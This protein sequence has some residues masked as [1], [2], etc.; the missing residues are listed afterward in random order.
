VIVKR[1]LFLTLLATALGACGTPTPAGTAG[2]ASTAVA[3]TA[4]E[5]A[6]PGAGTAVTASTSIAKTGTAGATTTALEHVTV[7][8]GY[9]P[10]VQF[11]P[12]YVAARKGYYAAEGLDV[13]FNYGGNVNDLLLQSASGKLPFLI[14][15]GDEVLVARTQQIPVE[16][17]FL[18][19]QR[20]PVAVFSKQAAGITRPQDLKGKTIGIPGRYGA[21]YIG[22]RGLL[23]AAG[24]QES[25]VNLSEIGF[26]QF[27]AVSSGKVPVAVGYANNDA[28]RLQDAGMPVNV[29]KVGD[30]IQ[31]VNNG[32][33]VSEAY[34]AQHADTVRKF[35]RATRKGLEATLANPDDAFKLSLTFIPEIKADQQ[36]F[37][38]KVLQDTLS[39]WHTPD[40][41]KN[42]LGW[43]NPSA[44]NTTYT[45]LRKS[46]ILKQDTDPT[47]AFST[48]FVK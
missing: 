5:T 39:Y 45:F 38:R 17:V 44:W 3:G 48:A 29:I 10:N 21:T 1:L 22:L 14:A 15:A 20:P 41:D 2:V 7:G 47:K 32:I 33:V 24:M 40:T 26:T 25:D 34:A 11:A 36:P 42:G 4:G 19:Y 35:V 13:A 9:I 46:G 43:L 6:T 27:E 31:L 30:Y 8:L 16:M 28:L 23:Y 18:L 12:F 37:Q